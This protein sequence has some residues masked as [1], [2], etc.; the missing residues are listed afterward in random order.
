MKQTKKNAMNHTKYDLLITIVE[1]N[2]GHAILCFCADIGLVSYK[3]IH[4]MIYSA[5]LCTYPNRKH[6]SYTCLEK[7]LLSFV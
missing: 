3:G 1:I 6:A 7:I 2:Q 5:C 4:Y